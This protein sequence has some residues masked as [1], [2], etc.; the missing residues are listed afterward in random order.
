M[1][2]RVVEHLSRTSE[3]ELLTVI[4][5]FEDGINKQTARQLVPY[6]KRHGVLISSG[7]GYEWR[8]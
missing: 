3:N 8:G 4:T 2:R 1:S 6:S 7:D 5:V